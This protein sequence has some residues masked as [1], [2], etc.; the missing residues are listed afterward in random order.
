MTS[1]D[2]D[3][4]ATNPLVTVAIPT[5]N[6]AALLRHCVA[7]ALAQ[8]YPNIEVLV[9]NNASTDH[10]S[11]VLQ[12][13]GDPRIR[14]LVNA[15]N[16]GL[17]GNWNQCVREARGTY[18]IILSDDN[19]LQPTFVEQ[20]VRLLN[21]EPGLPIVVGAFDVVMTD[22]SRTVPAVLPKTLRTGIWDGPAIL[23]EHLRG[24]FSFGTLS[25]A[26]RTDLLRRIGGFPA[27]YAGGG[28]EL[29]LAR[30][31]LKGRAG[32]INDTCASHVFHSHATARH[33]AGLDVDSRFLE[34]CGA[35]EELVRAASEKIPEAQRW[36]QMQHQT[37]TYIWYRALQ[38]LAFFRRE[39][40]SLAEA[41][42]HLWRWRKLLAQGS[43]VN[44][45]AAL[46]MGVLCRIFLPA[47]LIHVLRARGQFIGRQ[48][49][50]QTS[51]GARLA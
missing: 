37:M 9:S 14:E 5:R 49:P 2:Q 45:L 42:R 13:F 19:V 22:E 28:E 6:R 30:I 10:T 15:Q 21:Q 3:N 29:V 51:P 23:I 33:S 38:E 47:P 32:F 46:R 4:D 41:L 43:V 31:L 50:V 44:F 25:A 17:N 18:L 26:I 20:C 16:I 40:A 39:G 7:S 24:A 12:S 34:L 27:D 48:T 36:R 35:M 11:D 8:T 1:V